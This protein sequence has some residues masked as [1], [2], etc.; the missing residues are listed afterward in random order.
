MQKL[1][2]GI[3]LGSG[4][5]QLCHGILMKNALL[6]AGRSVLRAKGKV[7]FPT[8]KLTAKQLSGI[9]KTCPGARAV[10]RKF[11]LRNE[12]P[13]SLREALQDKLPAKELAIL[14]S[15]YDSL[16][17]AVILELPDGLA[18]RAKVIADA[19]L[20]ISKPTKSVFIK[21]GAHSGLFRA[22]PVEFVAGEKKKFATYKEHGCAFRI[23]LGKVF[24]SPR[25][26]TERKR[27]ASQIKE[28]EV[29]AALFAGVGP[30]P[31]VFA[32]NSKMAK[33]IA[34]E[35]NPVA[36]EDMAFNIRENKAEGKV[37]PVLGDVNE[38][39]SRYEGLCDRAV[40]PLPKG[41]ED[42]LESAIRYINP[43]GGI[44]HYYQFVAR[45][46]PFEIP[47]RQ[48]AAA[49]MKMGRDFK[50]LLERKVREYSP[51]IIQVVV[52]FEVWGK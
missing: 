6:D 44:V 43:K 7:V 38:L 49:C 36:V 3:E 29:V 25:L 9:R 40:M 46:N 12:K 50:V 11:E 35:L 13:H 22:E 15:S 20:E 19:L 34:I 42:F 4:Q 1:G 48:I 52:D 26:S 24:F 37:I 14:P 39:S 21:T 47:L 17:D 27:I 45:E 2:D 5:A 41:G 51:D 28:G 8:K 10:R 18:G 30:F 33:A 31:I 16:G 32:K 23:S